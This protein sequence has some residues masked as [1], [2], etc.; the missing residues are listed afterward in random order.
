VAALSVPGKA[1]IVAFTDFQ[2]PFCRKLAPVLREVEDNWGDRVALVRKMAPLSMHPGAMPA[3]LAYVCTPEDKR[4]DMARRLYEAQDALLTKAGTAIIAR[5][6]GVDEDRFTR[7]IEGSAAREQV[8]AD[9]ALFDELELH[10]LPYTYIGR[11]SVAGFNP[12]AAH[13][14]GAEIF[15]QDRPSLPL[16][17]MVAAAGAVAAGL[18]G[19]TLKLMP[20]GDE[21]RLAAS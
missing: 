4:E 17:W 12:D 7:C 21:P 5:D 2:C 16:W 15:D 8:A 11:R 1:T 10:G 14:Y 18:A 6:L 9:K 3:A 19:L 13:K 20:K